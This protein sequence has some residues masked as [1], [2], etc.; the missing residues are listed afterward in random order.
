M[1]SLVLGLIIVVLALYSLRH[2]WV[3][4]LGWTWIS[5]MNP[6]IYSWRLATMP[7]A[8]TVAW[9]ILIGLFVTKD[10]RNFSIA[11]EGLVL[12]LFMLWMCIVLPFSYDFDDSYLLWL[13]IM[14]I[15]LMIVVALIVLHS[16][17]HIMALTWVLVGSIGFYGVKGG[18]FTLATG[19]TYHVW[20]PEGTYIG[21]NNEVALALVMIIPLMWFLQLT[22]DRV[23]VKRGLLVAMVLCAVAAL[24]SQSRGA[25]LAIAAMAAL[26]WW[27]SQSRIK[28]GLAF[29]LLATLML[30]FMP[31]TWSDR[32]S[33]IQAYD[34]DDSAMQRINAWQ[35]AW[36]IAKNNLFGA[37]FIVSRPDI[38]ALYSPIPT[39]CRAAHSIYF[40]VLGEQGFIGLFLFLILWF[41]V[42]RSARHLRIEGAKR[43][44]TAWL[45]PLGAMV[46]VSL[47]GYA[48]G[49][50]FL[51]LSYYDLPYNLLVLV[52]LGRRWLQSKAYVEEAQQDSAKPVARTNHP[53][54]SLL[55]K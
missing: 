9:A 10:Q 44:E 47:A 18:L 21:G 28:T 48:V 25:L 55:S 12:I 13:R 40:M 33:T 3:G 30:G 8:A 24:G 11:R 27:R 26:L 54:G 20:G 15:D 38:C 45:V 1:I 19:G 43:P 32:M 36:N 16:K 41:L 52:V 46:Q 53:A 42:W 17:T 29:I 6:H 2:P 31:D 5:L 49:G 35:M 7:V 23:L 37:G 4:I 14:K 51:S 34:E 50:A 22:T 39:D